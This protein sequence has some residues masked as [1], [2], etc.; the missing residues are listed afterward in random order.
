MAGQTAYVQNA[1]IALGGMIDRAFN[2]TEIN[3]Y[4]VDASVS[5]GI[6]E[7]VVV[8]SPAGS[9]TTVRLP[10]LTGEITGALY[11]GISVRLTAREPKNGTVVAD[12][13]SVMYAAKDQLP[14]MRQGC[15]YVIPEAGGTTKGNAV[16]ARFTANG[17]GKLQL[18]ALRLDADTANAVAI[19]GAKWE[20]TTTSGP[21]RVRLFS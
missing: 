13:G 9:D 7:G 19:P 21:A 2:P 16:F 10:A 6:P 5:T 4:T 11:V 15:I 17:A 20:D 1:P 8:V 12:G 14:V 3:S 18:G